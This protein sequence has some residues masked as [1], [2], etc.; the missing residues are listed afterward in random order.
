MND[1]FKESI[2]ATANE[3][4]AQASDLKIDTFLSFLYTSDVTNRYLDIQLQMSEESVSKTGFAVLHTLILGGGTMIPTEISRRIFRS[5][6]SVTR[7]IDTLE[8]QGLVKRG[9]M[10]EDR[11]KREVSITRKGLESVRRGSVHGRE[12]VGHD[13]IGILTRDQI[14]ELNYILKILR[15]HTLGLINKCS[16]H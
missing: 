13:I 5:K 4:R 8:N 3:I 1:L 7:I 10:G 11:R 9:S 12:R 14:Q 6:H 15:K 2:E 16:T